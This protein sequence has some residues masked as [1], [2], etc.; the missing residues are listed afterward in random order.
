MGK[1]GSWP[2]ATAASTCSRRSCDNAAS[3]SRW[4]SL[5]EISAGSLA[6]A[7]PVDEMREAPPLRSSQARA[8]RGSS[9]AGRIHGHEFL[10]TMLL[11]LS[12]FHAAQAH[13]NLKQWGGGIPRISSGG[14]MLQ[15]ALDI[16]SILLAPNRN[17]SALSQDG[18]SS[19]FIKASHSERLLPVRIPARRFESDRISVFCAYFADSAGHDQTDRKRCVDRFLSQWTF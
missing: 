6:A 10:A 15:L 16:P 19:S 13:I 18:P 12:S 1:R 2:L 9:G 17:N 7:C 8:S 3:L 11:A 14:V 4:R 5:C